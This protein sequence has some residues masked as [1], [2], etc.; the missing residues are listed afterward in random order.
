[1]VL[2]GDLIGCVL[3]HRHE[4]VVRR[5]DL[6]SVDR[7][8]PKYNPT[9]QSGCRCLT[10]DAAMIVLFR[11]DQARHR[12]RMIGVRRVWAAIAGILEEIK[13]WRTAGAIDQRRMIELETNI[14]DGDENV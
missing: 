4:L 13:V 14:G 11:R 5:D 6:T 1:M 7:R 9:R 12:G 8:S 10:N 3:K 2:D